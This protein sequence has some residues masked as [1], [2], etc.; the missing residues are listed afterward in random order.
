M[1]CELECYTPNQKRPMQFLFMLYVYIYIHIHINI[2]IYT[3]R[4][5]VLNDCMLTPMTTIFSSS[6]N[7]GFL[8]GR[9]TPRKLSARKGASANWVLGF[10]GNG[11]S[12]GE[13]NALVSSHLWCTWRFMGISNYL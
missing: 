4:V 7:G 10:V 6:D 12:Y 1:Q 13:Q 11:F 9:P 8:G 3:L 5:Q 2:Y